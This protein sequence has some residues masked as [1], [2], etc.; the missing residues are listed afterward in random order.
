MN[1]YDRFEAAIRS[2]SARVRATQSDNIRNDLLA[3]WYEAHHPEDSIDIYAESDWCSVQ[4][5]SKYADE[6]MSPLYRDAFKA[7]MEFDADPVRRTDADYQHCRQML[8]RIAERWD[9]LTPDEQIKLA[10][11]LAGARH[12]VAFI[13]LI[14]SLIEGQ[15]IHRA[16]MQC[17]HDALASMKAYHKEYKPSKELNDF[18][19]GFKVIEK[20]VGTK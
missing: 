5:V 4:Y 1:N 6:L 14:E 18:L 11:S 8:L 19:S 17:M 12:T 13:Q 9:D 2:V 7:L 3:R 16:R 15:R 20:G 10:E